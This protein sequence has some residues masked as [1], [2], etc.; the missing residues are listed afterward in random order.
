MDVTNATETRVSR[1]TIST[2][3]HRGRHPE[4]PVPSRRAPRSVMV[5]G[6]QPP[7][8]EV[9]N[10]VE[11]THAYDVVFVETLEQAYSTVKQVS[12]DLIVLW[13]PID[14]LHACRVLSM[15]KLDQTTARIPLVTYE[16]PWERGPEAPMN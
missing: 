5:I 16:A 12:P 15:L 9:L 4:A 14:D 7:L 2:G 3:S 10:A 11:T 8:Q 1:S 6:R 13:L